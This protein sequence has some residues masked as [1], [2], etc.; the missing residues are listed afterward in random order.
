MKLDKRHVPAAGRLHWP[1][2]IAVWA[3]ILVAVGASCLFAVVASRR[4][5][6]SLEAVLLQAFT[7][8][9]GLVGSF[10]FG[11]Q[12][13]RATAT[14]L[15]KPHARSAFRRLLSLYE[16]L[17]RLFQAIEGAR[18]Q[19]EPQSGGG[20]RLDVL[21]VIV[22]EELATANDALED[23]RDLIPE[24]VAELDRRLRERC[25]SAVRESND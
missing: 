4:P 17:G 10:L 5:L 12:S 7:L 6:T 24:D 13:A 8:G 9:A 21:Q 15:V 2:A 18:R 14:E 19:E 20:S 1:E 3:L 23:W 16:S 22:V 25:E 11:R